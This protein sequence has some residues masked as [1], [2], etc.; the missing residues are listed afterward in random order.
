[1][2]I[3]AKRAADIVSAIML[4]AEACFAPHHKAG[5]FLRANDS[6]G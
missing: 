5:D 4:L 2:T 3:S 6:L 1:M